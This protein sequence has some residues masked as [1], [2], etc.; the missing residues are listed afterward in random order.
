[1]EFRM[2]DWVSEFVYIF[3]ILYDFELL[4][5]Q[6]DFFFDSFFIHLKPIGCDLHLIG[7]IFQNEM[8]ILNESNL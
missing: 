8:F 4:L 7:V 6:H 2:L 5:L 1:M 3:S